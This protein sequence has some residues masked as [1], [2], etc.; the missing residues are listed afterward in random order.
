MNSHILSWRR[1]TLAPMGISL[2]ILK[3]AM[4]FLVLVMMGFWPVMAVRSA[5]TLS[6]TFTLSLASPQP[7]LTTILAM[8]GIS[9]VDL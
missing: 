8:R 9:M 4:G 5:T 1:V 6:S 7:Q 3:L 2:R